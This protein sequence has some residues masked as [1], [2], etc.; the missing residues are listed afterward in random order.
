MQMSFYGIGIHL[1]V[2]VPS[3]V[4]LNP[5]ETFSAAKSNKAVI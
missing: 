2:Q 3:Y 1:T 5:K 4:L